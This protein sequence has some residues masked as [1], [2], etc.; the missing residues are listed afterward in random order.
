MTWPLI[1]EQWNCLE[2]HRLTN[3]ME[4]IVFCLFCHKNLIMCSRGLVHIWIFRSEVLNNGSGDFFVGIRYP[5]YSSRPNHV[6]VIW[7]GFLS[8]DLMWRFGHAVY[9]KPSVPHTES[10]PERW[11]I[12]CSAA[13]DSNVMHMWSEHSVFL[14]LWHNSVCSIRLVAVETKLLHFVDLK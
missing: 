14:C 7:G 3:K 5:I 11:I 12:Q 13:K 9:W 1:N 2:S 6:K 10:P 4:G 8:R